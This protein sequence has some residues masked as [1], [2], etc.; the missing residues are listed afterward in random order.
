MQVKVDVHGRGA[1]TRSGRRWSPTACSGT[2]HE[3]RREGRGRHRRGRGLGP[4]VRG[5]ARAGGR[6]RWWSTT[7]K[8]AEEVAAAIG[9]V[10][11]PGPV[12][13]TRTRP[14]CSSRPR[15]EAFGRLDVMVTNA[16]VLRDKV[17]WKMTDED[18]DLVVE[19]H[20]RGTFTCARAA[21][22]RLREQ[23]EGGRI[24]VVG[25]PAGPVRQLRA[26]E[27]RGGQ[28]RDRGLRAHVGDGARARRRHGQRD[29][30]DGVDGDDRD[31]PDLR[32][33]GRPRR[34]SRPRSGASTRS[35]RP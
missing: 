29:R 9:G 13:S 27:L 8:G 15:V 34:S 3:A 11:A 28:G 18:F 26:D 35:G 16:G 23:G 21:A 14:T 32:A 22:I 19:T 24:V 25:S 30:P 31:D 10:A 7:S 2:T 1:A 12:G 33:A 6:R 4:R 20:L 5:G 17:L